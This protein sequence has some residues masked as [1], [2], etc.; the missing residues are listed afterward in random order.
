MSDKDGMMT[1]VILGK[2][3]VDSG[4]TEWLRTNIPVSN[5]SH[6]YWDTVHGHI[7]AFTNESDAIMFKLK[8]QL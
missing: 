1:S 2:K 3:D 8:Y 5:H 7:V 4:M 6:H